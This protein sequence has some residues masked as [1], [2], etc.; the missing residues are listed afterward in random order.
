MQQNCDRDPREAQRRK[1]HQPKNDAQRHRQVLTHDATHR[2]GQGQRV[3]QRTQMAGHQRHVGGLE[4]QIRASR[5]HC[6]PHGG[7]SHGRG[8]V[9]TVAHH[10]DCAVLLDEALDY[11][12]LLVRQQLGEHFVHPHFPRHSPGDPLRVPREHHQAADTQTAKGSQRGPRFGAGYIQ[13]SQNALRLSRVP[14]HRWREA[15]LGHVPHR[16]L[17]GIRQRLARLSGDQMGAA[18]D[19]LLAVQLANQAHPR[20]GAH[21]VGWRETYPLRLRASKHGASERMGGLTFHRRRQFQQTPLVLP[22][23]WQDFP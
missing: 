23:Q 18:H 15:P 17:R 4:R 8:I 7:A 19:D 12:H 11:L 9:H 16:R 13:E 21:I 3:G 5:T 14:H 22:G 2:P 6:D 10:P 20:Y 1:R